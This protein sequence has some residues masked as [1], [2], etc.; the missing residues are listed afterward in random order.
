MGVAAVWKVLVGL[1]LMCVGALCYALLFY[2]DSWYEQSNVPIGYESSLEVTWSQ[3][4]SA[5]KRDEIAELGQ[6]PL[7]LWIVAD[8]YSGGRLYL[9]GRDLYQ[10]QLGALRD[11]PVREV[12]LQS[13][14][15]SIPAMLFFGLS[16][17][18]L[19]FASF[20][21]GFMLIGSR[22]TDGPDNCVVLLSPNPP[23]AGVG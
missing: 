22:F 9:K 13:T 18:L 1:G 10:L 17:L 4:V 3:M 19:G 15:I 6:D 16:A 7:Q 12:D 20:I 21:F 23:K 8:T 14:A 5:L 11:L 2:V